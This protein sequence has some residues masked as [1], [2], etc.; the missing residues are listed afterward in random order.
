[1]ENSVVSNLQATSS[2]LVAETSLQLLVYGGTYNE[3]NDYVSTL[4]NDG[5]AVHATH[6][7]SPVELDRAL[8]GGT[9]GMAIIHADTAGAELPQILAQLRDSDSQLP[10]LLLAESSES[11]LP[12]TTN[13]EIR[14][15]VPP[16]QLGHLS[17]AVRREHRNQL[18]RL[19]I[20]RLRSE[21]EAAEQRCG[22]LELESLDAIAY[23]ADGMHMSVNPG[24]LSL[25]GFDDAADMEGLPVMDLIA[26]EQRPD[27][28]RVL[29]QLSDNQEVKAQATTCQTAGGEH[30]EAQIAFF[31]AQLEGEDCTQ[32]VLRRIGDA[33]DEE[34]APPPES[35]EHVSGQ[36][37]EAD[38]PVVEALRQ[39]L[40]D[41]LLTLEYQPIVSLQGDTREHYA[42]LLRLPS[43]EEKLLPEQ[44]LPQ[45][46][47]AGLLSEIDRWVIKASIRELVQQRAE[48]RKIHF[49]INL[50]RTCL[51]DESLLLWI[52]DCLRDHDAKGAWL[53][54][55]LQAAD[56]RADIYAAQAFID[57][58]KKINCKLAISNYLAD[59]DSD[60]LT[61]SIG[62]DYIKLDPA[63]ITNLAT[64][65]QQQDNLNQVNEKL[66]AKGFLTVVVG[67]ESG[68]SLSV[69]W[70]ISV[71][72]IQGNF[73]QP[74]TTEI[75]GEQQV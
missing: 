50:S 49:F 23:I 28:K 15:I 5:L 46:E 59:P 16:L 17:F 53:T 71:N 42:V 41:D 7:D 58:L 69:L 6:V 19:E 10:I 74:A 2:R 66:Q 12:L 43:G 57:G 60:V 11:Y 63:Y 22:Q 62:A 38:A 64:D 33:A 35:T 47:Q 9:L 36:V 44:F 3:V 4:R 67:V 24:Y 75:I 29:R 39:A 32:I 37:N 56:L 34:A 1:M 72:F 18:H 61:E 20:A 73:L 27:F 8:E 70:N 31:P 14:D 40:N 26:P 13:F 52:C 21:L 51:Q 65:Q 54:L 55:Q 68:D 45:A 25:F 30:F 48:G